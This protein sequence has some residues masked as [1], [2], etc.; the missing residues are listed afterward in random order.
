MAASSVITVQLD[1]LILKRNFPKIETFQLKRSS[2][3][4]PINR[5]YSI[6][7][8]TKVMRY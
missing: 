1:Q 8:V 3:K 4:K 5:Q 2:K 6:I 7:P